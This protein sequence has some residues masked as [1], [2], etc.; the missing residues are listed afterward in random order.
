[1]DILTKNSNR[2][3]APNDEHLW[4]Q[5]SYSTISIKYSSLGEG[6]LII[7]NEN[8]S[9]ALVRHPIFVKDIKKIHDF[10][11]LV[12]CQH[13]CSREPNNVQTK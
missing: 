8:I 11:L 6:L 5:R 2:K 3:W 9:Y 1:M 7:H 4:H 13:N 10:C 12:V